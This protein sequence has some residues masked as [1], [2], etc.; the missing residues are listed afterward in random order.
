[1]GPDTAKTYTQREIHPEGPGG[2]TQGG[3]ISTV[4]QIHIYGEDFYTEGIYTDVRAEGTYVWRTQEEPNIQSH[5]GIYIRGY[6]YDGTK[7]MEGWIR[8]GD[9]QDIHRGRIDTGRA[10]RRRGHLQ[11]RTNIPAVESTQDGVYIRSDEKGDIYMEK[12]YT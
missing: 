4:V 2:D 11:E 8:R 1:M 12:A 5:V 7:H 3:I 9:I 6:T 10:N